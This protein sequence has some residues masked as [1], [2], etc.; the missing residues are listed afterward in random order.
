VRNNG[1]KKIFGAVGFFG[2][3]TRLFLAGIHYRK[4]FVGNF[5]I[6]DAAHDTRYIF[7]LSIVE[8]LVEKHKGN[9]Q[10]ESE[11]IG[12]GSTFIVTLPICGSENGIVAENKETA[13]NED[14]LLEKIKILVV[15]DDPDSREVL[16]LLLEQ[17]G[18]KVKSAESAFEAINLL[19]K[20]QTDLPDVIVSDLAMPDED[21]YSLLTRIRKLS[22]EKGGKIPAL[23]LS[24]F[25][26]SENK[27]KAYDAGFQ[28]YHTKPF[29]PDGIIQDILELLKK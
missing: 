22:V 17:S 15:E 13:P 25:A 9:V 29:E 27:Q 21:G 14:K 6:A 12:Y 8:I 3:V 5:T 26:T 11:G 7:G 20:S 23:A 19:K 2:F 16:Q 10:V 18:A 28:K 24:A 4:L 1:E